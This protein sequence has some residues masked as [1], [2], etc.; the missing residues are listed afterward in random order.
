VKSVDDVPPKQ[1]VTR[2]QE[3]VK[4]IE[5]LGYEAMAIYSEDLAPCAAAVEDMNNAFDDFMRR[6]KSATPHFGIRD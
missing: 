2:F 4:T 6:L 5:D 1:N 3:I